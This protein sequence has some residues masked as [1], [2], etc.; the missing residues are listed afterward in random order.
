MRNCTM[1]NLSFPI[2]NR[3]RKTS[4]AGCFCANKGFSVAIAVAAWRQIFQIA[5]LIISGRNR[6]LMERVSLLT[7]DS[8]TVTSFRV[9]GQELFLLY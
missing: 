4:C 2:C 7:D 3:L 1:R 9:V 5:I 8:T 6:H